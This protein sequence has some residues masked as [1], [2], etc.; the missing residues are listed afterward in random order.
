MFLFKLMFIVSG[1]FRFVS[2]LYF[3]AV[4]A[5]IDAYLVNCTCCLRFSK[6]DNI[7]C[8]HLNR[9]FP[10]YSNSYLAPRLG[11]VKQKK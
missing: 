2:H 4:R 8:S 5:A 10:I 11:G 3:L 6:N 7:S 9:P 1:V